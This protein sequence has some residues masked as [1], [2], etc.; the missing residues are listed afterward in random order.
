MS[1]I[2]LKTKYTTEGPWG[3]TEE[4]TVYA[5]HNLSCDYVTFFDEKGEYILCVPDTIDN[6]LLD[7][8]NRLYASSTETKNNT[9][10]DVEYMDASDRAICKM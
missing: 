3:T 6:N 10:E 4:H 7:A 8:I 2:R 1:H 9:S 5:H